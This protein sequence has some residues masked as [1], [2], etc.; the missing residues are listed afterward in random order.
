MASSRP[1]PS[2]SWCRVT[3]AISRP[4]AKTGAPDMPC[5]GDVA[6]SGSGAGGVLTAISK[7]PVRRFDNTGAA[8]MR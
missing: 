5:H 7:V 1:R 3:T 4:A 8:P 2:P 6:V